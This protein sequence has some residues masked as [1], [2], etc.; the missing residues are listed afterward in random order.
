MR[1]LIVDSSLCYLTM[2][3]YELIRC[4]YDHYSS[5]YLGKHPKCNKITG[6]Q[7]TQIIIQNVICILLGIQFGN[8]F[9]GLKGIRKPKKLTMSVKSDEQGG[10]VIKRSG[11]MVNLAVYFQI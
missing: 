8:I 11:L 7:Y 9:V 2:T 5:I 10:G 3:H 4:S 6:C 1:G